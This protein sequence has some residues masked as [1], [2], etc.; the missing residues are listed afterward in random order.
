[1]SKKTPEVG[2]IWVSTCD[3]VHILFVSKNAVRLLYKCARIHPKTT[4]MKIDTF[5]ERFR[6]ASKAKGSISDLFEVKN[7]N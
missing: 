7:E 4:T 2:E 3:K 5:C 6:Y 1:M